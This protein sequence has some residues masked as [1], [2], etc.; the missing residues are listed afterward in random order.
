[1]HPHK[2][3]AAENGG[4]QIDAWRITIVQNYIF[5][6]G[7][8][9]DRILCCLTVC[10]YGAGPAQ[11]YMSSC[12]QTRVRTG[13]RPAL[14]HTCLAGCGL[15][16]VGRAVT[17]NISSDLQVGCAQVGTRQVGA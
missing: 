13:A 1:M 8:A 7:V 11:T 15:G 3:G 12:I 10:R 17:L 4:R 2:R 16:Q 14:T 6:D 5:E 9:E